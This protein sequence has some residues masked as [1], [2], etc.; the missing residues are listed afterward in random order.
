MAI[1]GASSKCFLSVNGSRA[2]A[3]IAKF[4]HKNGAIETYT[5]LF[6]NQ[7]GARLGFDMAHS[8]IARLDGTLHFLSRSFIGE[9]EQLVHAS[10]MVEK[11][12][13]ANSAE[14]ATIRT[15]AQ[16]Q[17]TFDIDLMIEVIRTFCGV[18]FEA[19]FEKF[20]EMLV[21]DAIIG[22]MD[23][24]PRNWGVIRPSTDGGDEGLAGRIRFAPIYDSARAL[25]WDLTD[26]K[27]ENLLKSPADLKRYID[28]S[29]PRMG[30]P[31]ASQKCSH[32][33]L[34]SHVGER[35]GNTLR[36]VVRSIQG[37]PSAVAAA[38]LREW[39]FCSKFSAVRK[40]AMVEVINARFER[41]LTIMRKGG[42]DEQVGIGL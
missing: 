22:S 39:P 4:A 3:Y 27:I 23:R 32:F 16:Q 33:S 36:G 41:F 8:G 40:R 29:S 21:F 9:G 18:D 6:N 5:E 24:H 38:L 11:L 10:L 26:A 20:M 15:L 35:Y 19:V 42:S 31:N 13:L 12:G 30:L 1:G 37:S 17:R 2:D 34:L 14:I 28:H 7:F 25:M